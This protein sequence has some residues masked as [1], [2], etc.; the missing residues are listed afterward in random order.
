MSE[1]IALPEFPKELEFGRF[2]FLK[3]LTTGVQGS[4]AL[5]HDTS[6][7]EDVAVKFEPRIIK[8]QASKSNFLTDCVLIIKHSNKIPIMPKY[9]MN[10]TIEGR[11]YLIM[12]YLD[13]SLEDA[14][15]TDPG[16]FPHLAL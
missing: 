8:G 4:V 9:K 6:E 10:G 14:L 7:R 15:K 5:Y 13:T 16:K 11:R 2:T 3:N 12:E 1:I